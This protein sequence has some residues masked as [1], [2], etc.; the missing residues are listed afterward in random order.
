MA[1]INFDDI[2]TVD[3]DDDV[4]TTSTVGDL[5]V[6]F[7][8]LTT[9]GDLANGIFANADDVTV[10]HFA[11][12]ETRGLGAAGIFVEGEN[13]RIEN[14]GSVRTTGNLTEDELF[15]SEG[16]FALGDGFYIANFGKVQVEGDAAS[17]MV[18]LGADGTIINFNLVES[19]AAGSSVLVADGDRSQVIN[20]GQ[21]KVTGT[22]T[23]AL[24]V[25]G[26]D[27]S[28][29]NLGQIVLT[30]T[31]NA[32][33]GVRGDT[34]LTNKGVIKVTA[35]DSV[36]MGGFFGD[37]HELSNF[38]TI[39]IKG[40]FSIGMTADGAGPPFLPQEL[41]AE[42]EILNAG[43]ILTEGDLSFGISLGVRSRGFVPAE[44]GTI[45]NS[46]LIQT[47]GDGAAGI[48]MIGHGHH[49][50]NMGRVTTN[51]GAAFGETLEVAINAASVVVSGDDAV[52]E[53][54]HSGIIESK[55]AASAAVELNVLAATDLPAADTSSSLENFGLIK[56][57][58]V[59]VLGGAG[60]EQVINHGR[61]VGDV[62]LGAGDDEF[63]AD[64]GGVLTG[65]LKLGAGDDLVRV[66]NGSGTTRIADFIAGASSGDAIDVSAFFSNF[67]DL[68]DAGSQQGS[69]LVIALDQNDQLILAGV[70]L[71][72]LNAGD[73]WFV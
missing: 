36:G 65:T 42:H 49:L 64:S 55:K 24:W 47:K 8:E 39:K 57:V 3:E 52:V 31:G 71:N 14:Y 26:V 38:G 68:I 28:A 54:T 19:S 73:F 11:S 66:E 20:A 33:Q 15:F 10:R 59:A 27:A 17:G 53:N 25:G 63:V 43:S 56:A 4:L 50:I 45:T 67:D 30:E 51:G 21:V 29:L 37:H 22:D 5:I 32:M 12:I 48:V 9:T 18:G 23:A 40:V 72:A 6:N 69:N 7:G 41:G 70:Q 35:D 61:I 2:L 60:Q 58:K 16:I 34:H 44:D 13:A 1:I 46:G 62:D